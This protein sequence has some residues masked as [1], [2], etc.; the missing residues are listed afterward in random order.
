MK[1]LSGIA[2]IRI[3]PDRLIFRG[4]VGLDAMMKA[5]TE[6]DVAL[7]PVPYNGVTTTLQA[8]WMGVPVV[9]LKGKN[10]VSR[11]GASFL[12]AAGLADWVA[13]TEAAFVAR[14]RAAAADRQTL[15][16]LKQGLRSH[17]LSR[18]AWNPDRFATSFQDALRDIWTQSMTRA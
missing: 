12:S 15:I 9:T 2:E 10:F 4:P 5:Y 3:D 1:S 16:A 7:D 13:D 6:I 14:A 11:M 8:L 18:P 17:L